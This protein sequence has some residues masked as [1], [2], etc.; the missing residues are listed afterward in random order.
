MDY[1]FEFSVCFAVSP[2]PPLWVLTFALWKMSKAADVKETPDLFWVRQRGGPVPA[3]DDGVTMA[4]ERWE[5]SGSVP[6]GVW[7]MMGLLPGPVLSCCK[8]QGRAWAATEPGTNLLGRLWAP[9]VQQIPTCLPQILPKTESL[10]AGHAKPPHFSLQKTPKFGGKK[11]KKKEPHNYEC[12]SA[13]LWVENTPL[14]P[15]PLRSIHLCPPTSTK[16]STGSTQ[17]SRPRCSCSCICLGT[18]GRLSPARGRRGGIPDGRLTHRQHPGARRGRMR[19][20][21]LFLGRRQETERTAEKCSNPVFL[22]ES[23]SAAS[24]DGRGTDVTGAVGKQGELGRIQPGAGDAQPPPGSG[25]HPGNGCCPSSPLPAPGI[26]RDGQ[27]A[28][29][30]SCLPQRLQAMLLLEGLIQVGGGG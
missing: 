11:K 22:G 19:S 12:F 13:P 26:Y 20:G 3:Q 14:E 18:R 21:M 7:Q 6:H 5:G 30:G 17:N 23:S 25:Y 1:L 24:P 29:T 28:S 15:K 2:P 27:A 4:G 16:T 10:R 8:P 9:G